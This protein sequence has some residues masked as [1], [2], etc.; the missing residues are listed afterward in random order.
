MHPPID[1][2]RHRAR[3]H[4]QRRLAIG[5]CRRVVKGKI[6]LFAARLAAILASVQARVLFS[7]PPLRSSSGRE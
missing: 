4:R 7:A 3:A 6:R 2:D 1:Y 5:A